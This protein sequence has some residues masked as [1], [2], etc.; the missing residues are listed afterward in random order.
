MY[1]YSVLDKYAH[2][3]SPIDTK[4]GKIVLGELSDEAI[5]A[6]LNHEGIRSIEITTNHKK[7]KAFGKQLGSAKY[8]E[9]LTIKNAYRWKKIILPFI[10]NLTDE[11]NLKEI[12][13]DDSNV[14][15][16]DVLYKMLSKSKI[17]RLSIRCASG[18]SELNK[19]FDGTNLSILDVGQIGF[20]LNSIPPKSMLIS[21]EAYNKYTTGFDERKFIELIGSSKYAYFVSI[22]ADSSDPYVDAINQNDNVRALRI[23]SSK[24]TK[25]LNMR[26]LLRMDD[27][28]IDD[29]TVY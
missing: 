26:T 29:H 5:S 7:L 18:Y 14:I 22:W 20:Y 11:C 23:H 12:S 13:I 3:Y 9:R 10:D 27:I 16:I 8:A 4:K 19:L 21:T 1:D 17:E 2:K 24:R 15:P 28:S 6:V 25:P